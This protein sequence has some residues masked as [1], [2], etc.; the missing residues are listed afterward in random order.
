MR[1]ALLGVHWTHFFTHQ[2]VDVMRGWLQV[3]DIYAMQEASDILLFLLNQIPFI[4]MGCRKFK[5]L[6]LFSLL[7]LNATTKIFL[8]IF[9]FLCC[10]KKE[11]HNA[12]LHNVSLNLII[13]QP[14]LVSKRQVFHILFFLRG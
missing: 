1:S 10:Q 3:A 5:K 13:Y 7:L 9:I 11:Q 2:A 12:S 14:S 6:K 8:T 4:K